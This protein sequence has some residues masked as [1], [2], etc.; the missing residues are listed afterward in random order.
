[1]RIS[2]AGDGN[3]DSQHLSTFQV[4]SEKRRKSSSR[5][6]RKSRSGSEKETTGPMKRA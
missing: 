2:G 6:R 4:D 5:R 3:K 1:M